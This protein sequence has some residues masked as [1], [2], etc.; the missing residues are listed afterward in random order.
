L[1]QDSLQNS[2]LKPGEPLAVYAASKDSAW[3]F[4]ATGAVV[5]WVRS[6][7]VAPVDEEF[8]ERY[9]YGPHSVIIRDD[10]KVADA[11]GKPIC[12]IKLGAVIPAEGPDLLLPERGKNGMASIKR[13]RPEEDAALPW[14]IPFTPRNAAAAM[15][16]MMGEPYGWGGSDGHRDCSALTRD[17]FSLFGVWLPRN[18]ADQARTGAN[19]PLKNIPSA[20]RA[21]TIVESAIP[22]ATLIHMPGHIMIYL[23]L[24]GSAPVVFHNAW[25]VRV[26]SPSGTGR[27][28]IGRAA[29]TS[30]TAGEELK[31]RPGASLFID[32]I[33]LLAYPMA[34]IG[35]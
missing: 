32:R 9:M 16:Q 35:R 30:L 27:A 2:T 15:D 23:G 14:P 13:H 29:V 5:G 8:M 10:V 25:G 24:S 3:F 34:N 22:F 19:L 1:K 6:D 7:K 4:I 33:D 28:V 21:G 26:N 31:N 11:S 18:S 17:Y 12:T 20:Q